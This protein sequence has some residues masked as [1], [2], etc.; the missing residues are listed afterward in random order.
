MKS[1]YSF[2]TLLFLSIGIFAMAQGGP[3][4]SVEDRVKAANE[5]FQEA[6]KLEKEK[7]EKVDGF[8]KKY[9]TDQDK[10]R[11]ELMSG[12]ERPDFEAMRAKMAPLSAA[13]D[14]DL[15]TVLSEEQFSKWK[16]EVEPSLN[17]RRGP[18]GGGGGNRQ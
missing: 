3:R 1:K 8:F 15:K 16:S 6:F 14:K 4:R 18:G 10:V 2:L 12:G 17:P 11:A 9:Y 7:Q 5:K 13:L